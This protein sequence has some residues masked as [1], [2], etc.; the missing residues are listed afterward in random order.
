MSK[1]FRFL[2]CLIAVFALA[3]MAVSPVAFAGPSENANENAS[4]AEEPKDNSSNGSENTK[5]NDR[6]EGYEDNSK[7]PQET[8]HG[9]GAD[10]D[11][12]ADSDSNT[13]YNEDNDTNDGGTPNNV[14]DDG[15]NAHPSGKDRSVENGK[16][17]NQGKSESNPDDSKGPM[18]YEGAQGDDKPNGPGGTDLADQD[19]N[20]GCGN[21]DDFNDD[22]NGWCGRPTKPSTS[23]PTCP[24][25]STM[26]ANGKC[27][28]P[29]LCPNGST[30][31]ANGKCDEVQGEVIERCPNGSAMP[32]NSKKCDEVKGEVTCP[33]GSAMPASGD[34]EDCDIDLG[35]NPSTPEDNVL[36]ERIDRDKQPAKPAPSVLGVRLSPALNEPVAVAGAVL[37]FTGGE[38]LIFLAAAMALIA[39][40]VVALKVRRNEA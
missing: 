12:D 30:M 27:E 37:P 40:G 39:A 24:A 34:I 9:Q 36:G 25:G 19:G 8:N 14:S 15:D 3:L 18:R 35:E 17:G 38:A 20:N 33:D 6:K 13:A 21:D 32:A 26:G 16:S 4:K 29:K 28:T 2:S 7:T 5:G 11:G 1:K 23:K 31:P 10:N 22:N